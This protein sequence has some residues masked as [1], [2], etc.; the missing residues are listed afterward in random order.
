VLLR[1]VEPRPSEGHWVFYY[2]HSILTPPN[3]QNEPRRT[4]RSRR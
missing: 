4:R 1:E 3:R 2:R